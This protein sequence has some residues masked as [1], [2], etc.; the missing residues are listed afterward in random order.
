MAMQVV[1]LYRASCGLAC[2]A[3]VREEQILV[4]GLARGAPVHIIEQL[5]VLRVMFLYVYRK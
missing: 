2:G 3:P 5:F 4:S 1:I